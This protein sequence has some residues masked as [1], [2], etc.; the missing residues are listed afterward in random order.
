MRLLILLIAGALAASTAAAQCGAGARWVINPITGQLYCFGASSGTLTA[1]V[2]TVAG[3]PGTP[4]TGQVGIVSDG[5]SATDC[6]VGGGST[7]VLCAYNGTAWVHGGVVGAITFAAGPSGG[8]TVG[9]SGG[10][11]TVDVDDE[12]VAFQGLPN[13]F[14]A[15]NNFSILKPPNGT[16]APAAGACDEAAEYGDT[17][18]R[19]ATPPVSWACTSAGW[20]EMSGAGGGMADPGANGV[21]VRTAEDVTTARTITGTANRVSV[22]N[23][24]GVSGNP[25]LTLPNTIEVD[26]SGNAATATALAANPTDCASGEFATAIAANGDL[27]CAVPTGETESAVI[28]FGSIA[29]GACDTETFAFSGV[30]AGQAITPGFPSALNAGLVPAMWASATNTITVQLCNLSGGSIDP[31]SLTYSATINGAAGTS[32]AADAAATANTLALRTGSGALVASAFESSGPWRIDGVTQATPGAT[33]G[34]GEFSAVVNDTSKILVI[35]DDAGNTSV[36]ARPKTAVSGEALASLGTDG[37]FTTIPVG[38]AG[39][40]MDTRGIVPAL[41][42]LPGTAG[43]LAPNRA[44]SAGMIAHRVVVPC[45]MDVGSAAVDVTTGSGTSCTGGTCGLRFAIYDADGDLVAQSN[46]ITS[47]GTP[48]INTTGVKVTAFATP[49]SLAAGEYWYAVV[50]DS[51]AIRLRVGNYTFGTWANADGTTRIGYNDS[52]TTGNGGSLAAPATLPAL[53]V[54]SDGYSNP[55]TVFLLR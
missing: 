49:V 1:P 6:T 40:C 9:S 47:G 2:T 3:L 34:A 27:T 35:K 24:D 52:S 21:V 16:D 55:P 36:T 23:G 32:Y 19:L 14:T 22:T 38:G 44:V 20:Q 45:A 48:D 5:A 51:T 50:T 4:T 25:T 46:V 7:Y 41:G 39:T 42:A 31:A 33:P 28:D 10:T 30:T 15:R 17:Y 8:L 13:N 18:T 37:T 53:T 29:D 26:T 43:S 12:V 11:V 54:L